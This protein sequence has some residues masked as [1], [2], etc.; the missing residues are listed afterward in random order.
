M[1]NTFL[2]REIQEIT[3][4]D[5]IPKQKF[6]YKKALLKKQKDI[7]KHTEFSRLSTFELFNLKK[8]DKEIGNILKTRSFYEIIAY[9]Q[10]IPILKDKLY[11]WNPKR[12]INDPLSFLMSVFSEND[13]LEKIK[14]AKSKSLIFYT[15]GFINFES[16]LEER[17]NLGDLKVLE[18]DIFYFHKYWT[19]KK[20]K[21]YIF[22]ECLSEYNI[23]IR[24][25]RKTI[26]VEQRII[27][28]P[29]WCDDICPTNWLFIRL[30][31]SKS[32][33][34]SP[35]SCFSFFEV[36]VDKRVFTVTFLQFKGLIEK[37]KKYEAFWNSFSVRYDEEL[38][39]I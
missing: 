12:D 36:E 11:Y 31:T 32:F 14:A 4:G 34:F 13:L 30:P 25:T 1:E 5:Y 28:H 35:V 39:L 18:R 16:M 24:H 38:E 7:N 10:S 37:D 19:S 23:D 29:Y 3:H 8:Y 6:T 20:G 22:N 2:A 33:E 17:M 9:F 27:T 21:L 15:K 26:D